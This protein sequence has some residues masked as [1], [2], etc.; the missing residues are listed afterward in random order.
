MNDDEFTEPDPMDD[1][2]ESEVDAFLR[3]LQRDREENGEREVLIEVV[4]ESLDEDGY[5]YTPNPEGAGLSLSIHGKHAVYTIFF[6]ANEDSRVLRSY[7]RCPFLVPEEQ[8]APMA[9]ALTRAN[10]GLPLGNF[11]MDYSDGEVRFKT[12]VDVEGG[13][14][15]PLMVRNMLGASLAVCD[16]YYPAF[17][18]VM[19]AGDE[20]AD[21]IERVEI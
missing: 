11:E 20:P 12:S 18:R 4:S 21:A 19:H 6:F 8:R 17:M 9:E 1:D 16:R 14:L 7:V 13:R 15:V 2:A 10:Y 3:E 5:T